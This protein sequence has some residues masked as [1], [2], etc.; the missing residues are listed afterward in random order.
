MD[1]SQIRSF[2]KKTADD[3]EEDDSRGQ[4]LKGLRA[5]KMISISGAVR[6]IFERL[7]HVKLTRGKKT[8]VM[9]AVSSY[10][11]ILDV[12]AQELVEAF[13]S[14]GDKE[15]STHPDRRDRI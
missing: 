9:L 2:L 13:K 4:K 10:A 5:G 12:I 7:R 11:A 3:D 1:R 14:G 8:A 6:R 15:T